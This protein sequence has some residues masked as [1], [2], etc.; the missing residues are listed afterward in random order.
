[1]KNKISCLIV[2]DEKEAREGLALLVHDI[3]NLE[4]IDTCRNGIEAIDRINEFKPDLLLLD[5]QMPHIDGF[6]V[7]KHSKFTPP[8]VIFI[9]AYDQYA[10]KAFEVHAVDYLLKPFT[11]ERFYE[12]LKK[13]IEKI[14]YR[15]KETSL[16]ALLQETEK[17][18]QH[19]DAII[20]D[21]KENKDRVVIKS[22]G[23]IHFVP[24]AEVIWIEAY[25]YYIK[26]HVK[27]RFFLVR[28]TMKNMESKLPGDLFIRIHKS[29]IVNFKHIQRIE[30]GSDPK[31]ILSSGE[32]LNISRT[33]KP[34]LLEKLNLK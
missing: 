6:E 18:R 27:G 1:M 29:Y 26:V 24:V 32:S 17:Y 14:R 12:A 22:E 16:D 34:L 33:Y 15:N 19:K 20:F 10:L 23:K 25:D 13:A 8:A 7:L 9:T 4:L 11:D 30:A 2:D 5:I 3:E 31:V 21:K 28:E